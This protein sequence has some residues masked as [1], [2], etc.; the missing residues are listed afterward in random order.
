MDRVIVSNKFMSDF[1]S[2]P[3][4]EIQL[5]ASIRHAGEYTGMDIAEQSGS[6]FSNVCAGQLSQNL[7]ESDRFLT[8]RGPTDLGVDRLAQPVFEE[9]LR[10][11][12]IKFEGTKSHS[13]VEGTCIYLARAILK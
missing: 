8:L 4:S 10:T 9:L 11:V 2:L 13:E 5:T 12:S 1:N 7:G 6:L 3:R